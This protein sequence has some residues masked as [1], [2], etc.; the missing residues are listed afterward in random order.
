MSLGCSHFPVGSNDLSTSY[1]TSFN[2]VQ[3]SASIQRILGGSSGNVSSFLQFTKSNSSRIESPLMAEG[4]A[5]KSLPHNFKISRDDKV[6]R[7]LRFVSSDKL[8]SLRVSSFKEL[9]PD[10]GCNMEPAMD[11]E[12]LLLRNDQNVDG[13]PWHPLKDNTL[14]FLKREKE[15][16]STLREISSA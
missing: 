3:F 1:E 5:T 9:K 14:R 15:G 10:K 12:E 16:G 11:F 4:K 13:G 8:Q 2:D 6:P 7:L